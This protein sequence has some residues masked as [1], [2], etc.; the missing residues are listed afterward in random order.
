VAESGRKTTGSET[1]A[2]AP[3]LARASESSDPAVH[4]LIAE[5]RTLEMNL[6][7]ARATDAATIKDAEE[8]IAAV[9]RQLADLGF[10]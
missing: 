5:R 7:T 6:E 8:R 1:P 4:Q 3:A 9:D 2:P 10:C